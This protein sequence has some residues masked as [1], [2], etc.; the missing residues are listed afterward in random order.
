MI[1][2]TGDMQPGLRASA[3]VG[4]LTLKKTGST[5]RDA[6]FPDADITVA[7]INY[8]QTWSA[9]QNFNAGTTV[10]ATVD[11]NAGTIDGTTQASGTI[12]GPIAVG[13]TWTAAAAWTLP[14]LTLGGTITLNGQSFSGTCA[15]GGTYTTIDINGGTID[16][17]TIGASAPAAAT[18]TTLSQA[19]GQYHYLRGDATTD[20]SVRLS[21]AASGTAQIEARAGG[22]W[23][24]LASFA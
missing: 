16:G 6:T 14:A 10:I 8:A 7:G 3:I 4:F 5:A 2:A 22:S 23:A 18:V 1:F 15:N 21:S 24:I 17:T 9:A 20:G 12:N 19:G 13:G 11:I